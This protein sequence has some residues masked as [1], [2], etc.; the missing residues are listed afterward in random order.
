MDIPQEI[1]VH[2]VTVETYAGTGAYGDTY[3]PPVEVQ[4]FVEDSRRLVR[5][6]DGDQ[7]I[8]EATIYAAP[9]DAEKLVEKT[10]V[11]LPSGRS[12]K[13]IVRK[14]HDDGDMGAPQHVEASCE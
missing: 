13:V 4:C 2:T 14:I 7:V 5:N 12:S 3:A 10:L 1:L 8:S 9:A 6:A 11:T